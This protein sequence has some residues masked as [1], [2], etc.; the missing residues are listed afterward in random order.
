MTCFHCGE[1]CNGVEIRV[2]EKNFCCNGCKTVFELL[3]ENNLGNYYQLNQ[4]PGL[5][6]SDTNQ[7][8]YFDFLELPE[9]QNK[10]IQFQNDEVIKVTFY[11]PQIHCNSCI[12]LLESLPVLEERILLSEV[13][14][15]SKQVQISIQK[16]FGL[17]NLALFLNDLGYRPDFNHKKERKPKLS[18]S[19]AIKIGVA[20]FCFGN[21]MLFAFPEYLGLEEDFESF[22][23]LFLW[24]SFF[25][26]IPVTFYSGWDYLKNAYVGIKNRVL[27][28]DFPIAIGLLT[29][30]IRSS[31]ELFN[32]TGQ[33]Y[34]DSLAGL[35]FFLLIGKWFQ[36]R[37]FFNLTFDRDYTSFFPIAVQKIENNHSVITKL[38][39]LEIGDVLEI[40]SNELIPADAV[41][42]EGVAQLDYSFVTGESKIERKIQS[43]KVFAGGKLK[44]APVKIKLIRRTDS[45]YLTGLWNSSNY[46]TEIKQATLVT[47]SNKISKYFSLFILLL[48]LATAF[49][50]LV[51][52]STL[53]WSSVTA[54]LIVACP[55][56]LALSVPFTYGNAL[57]LLSKK[58][59][60]FRKLDVIDELTHITDIVFDKT[61][62]LTQ[63][64]KIQV[65][66]NALLSKEDEVAI[67][68]G[69]INS[70]HPLSQAI[71]KH[72][73][74]NRKGEV[75]C[76]EE[77]S[78]KGIAFKYK[79]STYLIGSK[80]FTGL[81]K[82]GESQNAKVYVTKNAQFLCDFDIVQQYRDNVESIVKELAETYTLHLLTGDNDAEK[83]HIKNRLNITNTRFYQSP[84]DKLTYVQALQAKGK[85]VLMIGDGINDSGALLAS[86][87]AIAVSNQSYAFTPASDAILD[88]SSFTKLPRF[89]AFASYCKKVVI[90]SFVISFLYNVVGLTIAV[91]GIFAPVLAAILMPLSSISVVLFTTIFIKIYQRRL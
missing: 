30:F 55:C 80:E 9:Y 16:D 89:I 84:K 36:D 14:F 71:A 15:S 31:F 41:I 87:V 23:D 27:N 26:S 57:R 70:M 5:R 64:N 66:C 54:V 50:W 65:R 2:E 85:K 40:R 72:I 24:L 32:P 22:K 47:I 42:L 69:T 51:A 39:D 29:L 73:N 56:A 77:F 79:D 10:Y 82:T 59:I 33:A 11:I 7:K 76:F 75:Q 1:D 21:I 25:L 91:Q 86:D 58:G 88:A 63:E 68:L 13:N 45:S 60:F 74:S 3:N 90:A 4:Q 48:S 46:S 17:K 61:G 52:D 62:T 28:M 78:G 12:W 53:I 49:Y 67:R 8:S 6:I 18:K 44:G 20:G 34:F 35:I 81:E 37:T 83:D 43:E 38:E 19:H